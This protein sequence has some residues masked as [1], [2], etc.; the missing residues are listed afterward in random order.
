MTA[1]SRPMPTA[2]PNITPM[3]DVLLVLLIIFMMAIPQ[4]RTI[5][6]SLPQP[7]VGAC[8]GGDAIVLEVMPGPSYRLNHQPVASSELLA[9]L[10]GV[11]RDR[12]EKII[13]IAGHPGVSYADVV[14]AMDIAK[15]AGVRVI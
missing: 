9:H 4:M 1:A 15:S 10:S 11:Y 14:S 12:P 7:C 8:A 5:D 13:Q 6:A 3:I 2:E